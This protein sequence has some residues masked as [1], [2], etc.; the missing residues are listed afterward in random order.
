MITSHGYE[1]IYIGIGDYRADSK[2]YAYVHR[3]VA[4]NILGRDLMK[5][6]QVHHIDG[7]RLNN[8]ETNIAVL[9]SKKHHAVF[10]RKP[11]SMYRMPM[12]PNPTISCGCGCGGKF[13]KYDLS[14]RPR[15]YIS[16][17]NVIKKQRPLCACGCGQRV[18]HI[19][20]IYKANHG[21]KIYRNEKIYC[22]CGCGTEFTRYDKHGRERKYIMGHARRKK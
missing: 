8:D 21:S 20:S 3:L 5:G 10:H 4:S 6:E 14:G 7:N 18:K 11:Q 15:I 19:K 17:H 9:P 22:M 12:E 1:K 16:G 2:G 13:T